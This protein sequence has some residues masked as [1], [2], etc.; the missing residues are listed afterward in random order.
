MPT[1]PPTPAPPPRLKQARP[2]AGLGRLLALPC[3]ALLC[4]AC[5]GQAARTPADHAPD[6]PATADCLAIWSRGTGRIAGEDAAI[7]AAIPAA[8]RITSDAHAVRL[9]LAG[10][11]ASQVILPPHSVCAITQHG[12]SLIITVE[13]GGIGL[14]LRDRGPHDRVLLRGIA[15]EAELLGTLLL[16]ER[17]DSAT[18]VLALVRGRILVRLRSSVAK[19]LGKTEDETIILGPRQGVTV[20][21]ETGIGSV[22]SLEHQPDPSESDYDGQL[23]R[24]SGLPWSADPIASAFPPT[25]ATTPPAGADDLGT[26]HDAIRGEDVFDDEDLYEELVED[27][28]ND[29]LSED[30]LGDFPAPPSR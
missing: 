24:D 25:T 1:L 28:S 23:R 9:W 16:L 17:A 3:L 10:C 5:Q 22:S 6:R 12:A 13:A 15:G 30:P 4:C 7:G 19:A 11:G 14:D 18:D 21:T 20:D 29:L 26:A 2:R 8:A 27:L